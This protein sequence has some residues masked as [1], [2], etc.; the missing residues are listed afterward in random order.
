LLDADDDGD[1]TKETAERS[2]LD[3]DFDGVIRDRS[4]FIACII[5]PMSVFF[6]E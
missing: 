6:Y 4:E 2:T 3:V 5:L 1:E